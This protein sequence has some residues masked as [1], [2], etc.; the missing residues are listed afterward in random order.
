MC[1]SGSKAVPT[2]KAHDVAYVLMRGLR[3]AFLRSILALALIITVAGLL[4]SAS[5]VALVQFGTATNFPAGGNYVG[6][7]VV[8]D[9][10]SDGKLDITVARGDGLNLILGTG[11]GAMVS[12]INSPLL[13]FNSTAIAIGDFNN[14]GKLDIV[15]ADNYS[16]RIL[17]GEGTGNLF[18]ITNRNDYSVYPAAVAVGDFN[19][20]GKTDLAIANIGNPSGRGV[21]IG[22]GRNDGTFGPSTNYTLPN[23][24]RDIRVGDIDG[25]GKPDLVIS[26][27]SYYSANSNSVCILPNKGDGTFGTPQYH[28]WSAKDAHT[29]LELGDFNGDGKLDIAVLNYNSRSVTIRLNTGSGILGAPNDYYMGFS[30][31]PTSIAS[32]DFNRDGIIDLIV[33]GGALARIL[34]GNGD[35]SFTIGSQMSAPSDSGSHGAVGVGDF[36]GDG[37]PDIALVNYS[38]NS[39]AIM[40]NQT[41][42]TLQITPM[43]GY[44][45]ISW[46]GSLG[47]GY[48]LEYTTNPLAQT[49]WQTFPYPAVQIGNQKAV[50]D[51]TTGEQKFYRLKK[52]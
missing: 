26:L 48:S 37:L 27:Q 1:E 38:G 41:L 29:S 22:F 45:Q 35:G 5:A 9:F 32:S 44:N 50:A 18:L 30:F 46:L 52:L 40:L 24:P 13:T 23:E 42:P 12:Y 47:V 20:D 17:L 6:A 33:R 14:D 4:P 2:S 34:L 31:P 16:T 11:S 36:N 51:W 3:S 8:A 10:N 15:E 39:I 21:A 19:G 25:D 43:A 49:G 7:M 28:A